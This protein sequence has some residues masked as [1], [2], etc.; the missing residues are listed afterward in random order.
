METSQWVKFL[1]AWPE[2]KGPLHRRLSVGIRQA[3][4]NGLAIQGTRLPSERDLAQALSLSRNTVVAAYN[5]LRD[6]GWLESRTGNGTWIRRES[7]A[8]R[9]A[10]EDVREQL[11]QNTLLGVMDREGESAIDFATGTPYPLRG[12]P[13]E[14][15]ALTPQENERLLRTRLY[16]PFGLPALRQTIAAHYTAK[17]LPTSPEEILVTT[18]AQ[19]GIMLIGSL[20]LQKGDTA[21]IEDPCYFGALEA[22]RGLGARL[23]TLPVGVAGVEPGVFRDAVTA[24]NARLAYLTPTFQNPTG[25]V[26]PAAARKEIVQFAAQRGL[27][28]IDDCTLAD[29]SLEVDIPEERPL[30]LWSDPRDTQGTVLTVGSLGKLA[31]AGLR[32]GWIRAARHLIERL[33]RMKM[34]HDLGTALPT[35]TLAVNLF[36]FYAQARALR[37][38]ELSPKRDL[39]AGIVR[40]HLP[41]WQFEL[42]AGGLFLWIRLPGGDS[43][44]LAQV[45]MRHRLV[46]LPGSNMSAG[47]RHGDMLR[48]PFLLDEDEL[49]EGMRR[50][51][52][53][54]REYT[55]VS[56][57]RGFLQ[58]IT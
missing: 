48:M 40:E 19:Q 51:I 31:W 21:L 7:H 23:H 25:T 39:L 24:S 22:F 8:I 13:A 14:V 1:G 20:F 50:L 57:R 28:V 56:R 43:S 36:A 17:G 10:Q 3:I 30:A 47:Q 42:P 27:P 58:T 55:E 2:H 44:E 15:T 11:A 54:W 33:V 6:E 9:N 35:Q 34:A 26:M 18:G 5:A 12:L 16:Y 38:A 37:R 41:D 45:A 52:G 32:I 49:R 53:A 29:I 46:L 4:E